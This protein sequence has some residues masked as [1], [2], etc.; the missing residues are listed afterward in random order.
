M[1]CPFL[2]RTAEVLN[3]HPT[4]PVTP[5]IPCYVL[6]V[7]ASD[8]LWY[9]SLLPSRWQFYPLGAENFPRP[10]RPYPPT[11]TGS[12][13]S[14]LHTPSDRAWF[15]A[16]SLLEPSR[17]I[18][19]CSRPA[20]WWCFRNFFPR[21][22]WF[23]FVWPMQSDYRRSILL[24]DRSQNLLMREYFPALDGPRI[25]TVTNGFSIPLEPCTM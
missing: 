25:A 15:L 2:H 9:C 19:G 3:R 18:S 13:R 4:L 12:N 22:P 17:R 23:L 16:R 10:H 20:S 14:D 5:G 11:K 24:L 1:S 7:D 6:S 21:R 8:K